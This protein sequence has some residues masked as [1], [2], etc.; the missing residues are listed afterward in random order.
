MISVCFGALTV[1]RLAM[2]NSEINRPIIINNPNEY[3]I[4]WIVNWNRC[5][6]LHSNVTHDHC[7]FHQTTDTVI[8]ACRFLWTCFPA[9]CSGFLQKWLRFFKAYLYYS[10]VLIHKLFELWF[11]RYNFYILLR[12]DAT[13]LELIIRKMGVIVR[14]NPIVYILFEYYSVIN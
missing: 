4:L 3:L 14:W 7:Q 13:V 6:R 8:I 1:E 12:Y 11:I 5:N 2:Y 10:A 9:I